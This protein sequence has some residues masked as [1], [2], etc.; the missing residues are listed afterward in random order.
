[1]LNGKAQTNDIIIRYFK[2]I[3]SSQLEA[4][5]FYPDSIMSN[6]KLSAI[7]FFHGGGWTR[8]NAKWGYDFCKYFSK[9][10]FITI[11]IEYRLAEEKA[12][13]TPIECIKDANSAIR[14]TRE[15]AKDLLIDTTK[16]VAAGFSAGGHLAA[17][18]AI[19]KG[20]D[21]PNENQAISSIPNALILWSACLNTKED[22]WFIEI[23]RDSSLVEKSSPTHNI[24]ENLP[25]TII[26]HG[27]SDNLLPI[28]TI[29]EFTEKMKKFGNRCELNI[30]TGQDHLP[31]DKNKKD[32]YLK[33]ERFLVDLGYIEH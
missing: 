8:G 19:L 29:K 13:N 18:T 22:P 25:P 12:G 28:W 21:E 4:H 2:E 11:S 16:I 5:I 32:V 9:L 20:F 14:W 30:Y 33:I 26:F 24:K 31:W 3:D 27:Y 23:L 6:E 1:M 17:S 15:N 10:N 7:V